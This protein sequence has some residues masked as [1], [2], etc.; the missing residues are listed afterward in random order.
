MPSKENSELYNLE[1]VYNLEDNYWWFMAK[2]HLLVKT[3]KSLVKNLNSDARLL[4]GGCG[5]GASLKEIQ[6]LLSAIGIEKYYDGIQFCKRRGI[7]NLVNAELE[8]LPF[9][10]EAFEVVL[11][12]DIL[13]HVDDDVEVLREISRVSKEGAILIIHVPAFMFLWC[14]HDVAVDHK[15]RY[16]ATQ[17][18]ERLKSAN[19]KIKS[20]RYRLCSFFILGII[21]KY[22]IMLKKLIKR[23]AAIKTYRPRVGRLLNY[24]LYTIVKIEDYLSNFIRVPF[25]SSIICIA[26]KEKNKI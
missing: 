14:D 4:D 3:V 7:G 25:G 10:Q 1:E 11:A 23:D 26:E 2:R 15:R 21:K 19:L 8:H 12:M 6:N 20:I 24:V 9:K 22:Y 16:T 5:T 18:V 13:E 17:L